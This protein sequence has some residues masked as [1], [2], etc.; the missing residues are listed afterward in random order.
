MKPCDSERFAE[1][2]TTL[3]IV[4]DKELSSAKLDIYYEFLKVYDIGQVESAAKH[5]MAHRTI[6]GTFPLISEFVQAIQYNGRTMDEYAE[7]AWRNFNNAVNTISTLDKVYF[8]DGAI[9]ETIK[10]LGG[11]A[12]IEELNFNDVSFRRQFINLY[13]GFVKQNP[14]SE[15]L[16]PSSRLVNWQYA[17]VN[18]IQYDGN[19]HHGGLTDEEYRQLHGDIKNIE[20]YRKLQKKYRKGI[21][22]YLRQ[23]G[24]VDITQKLIESS[25][26]KEI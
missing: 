2:M 15:I 21:D 18:V 26:G 7:L 24:I 4:F 14:M 12:N 11:W 23:E 16:N 10:R 1:I 22:E 19:I 17:P 3:A 20:D 8:E 9:T 5:I 6:T 25:T 13:T